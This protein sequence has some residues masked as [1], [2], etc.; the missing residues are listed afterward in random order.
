[1]WTEVLIPLC[2]LYLALSLLLW[3]C[4][5]LVTLELLSTLSQLFPM[6]VEVQ[7]ELRPYPYAYLTSSVS[8]PSAKH[9]ESPSQVM[10]SSLPLLIPSHHC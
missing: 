8:E 7:T 10:L 9:G 6:V 2:S 3:P 5:A 1:M 4:L